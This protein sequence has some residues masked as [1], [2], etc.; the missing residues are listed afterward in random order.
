MVKHIDKLTLKYCTKVSSAER[1]QNEAK[2]T[3]NVGRIREQ[4]TIKI[5]K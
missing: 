2:P 3:S 1:L 4:K 5:E